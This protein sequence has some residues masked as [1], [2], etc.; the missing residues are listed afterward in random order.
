MKEINLV[1]I[2]DS[3]KN[4][5][6]ELFI[7]Y[8]KYYSIKIKDSEIEDLEKF[9]N[10]LKKVSSK[11]SNYEKFFVGYTIP[12]ISK[13]FDLL[14]FDND[15]VLN[16]EIKRESST[17]KI[18]KQLEQNKYF[19]S[20]LDKTIHCYT[21][22]SSENKVYTLDNNN[23]VIESQI[24]QV[25]N[26]IASQNP[27]KI[28]NIDLLFN[29]S[30]YLVSPFNSTNQ[31][32][33]GK[34]FLTT[35]QE[36][37]KK[38]IL[39]NIDKSGTS[40]FSVKGKAGTGKTLL[41][42]DIAKELIKSESV[43]VIHCGQ[44]NEGHLLLLEDYNWEIISVKHLF[45]QDYSKYK[46]IILDEAQRIYPHFFEKIISE[47]KT[48]KTNL[49]L[50]HDE[51]Q[52]LSKSEITN[53]IADKIETVATNP[54]FELTNKIRTNKEVLNFTECIF[55]KDKLFTKQE[56]PNIEITYLQNLDET[57]DLITELKQT[58]WKVINYTPEGY[59]T[60]PYERFKIVDELL[61]S[62]KVIGQEFDNIVAVIDEHFYYKNNKLSTFGYSKKPYYH[63]T[64]MLYQIIS[65][66]R[67]KLHLII[68]RNEAI[69]SRCLE[70]IK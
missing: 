46:L 54:T 59:K 1:S 66:T 30:N 22:I 28:I 57:L 3:N 31:F 25:L 67:L 56:Y 35:H 58:G 40:I 52:T 64:K 42:Y 44:L 32:I 24:K 63:P 19:L 68:F 70:L 27:E 61:N 55:N 48:N 9:V 8:L 38:E 29:P 60:P 13:E 21:Y 62:H 20:F 17:D 36:N 23:R 5:S 12:Q 6:K 4:I 7:K 47:V 2:I 34:Y 53:R 16:I 10:E 37:I 69:L 39:K 65:R 18:K 50:S 11:I 26:I 15:S 51:E 14:R 33:R 49:I 41:I 43:L 45:Y